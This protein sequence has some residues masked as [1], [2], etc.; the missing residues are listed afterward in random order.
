M[1]SL[2]AVT[3]STMDSLSGLPS[4]YVKLESLYGYL[5]VVEEAGA[6]GGELEYN[7]HSEKYVCDGGDVVH[8]VVDELLRVHVGVV[9]VLQIHPTVGGCGWC[10]TVVVCQMGM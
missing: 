5:E 10:T 2:V 9:V 1:L 7:L 8:G 3:I 4:D 6:F